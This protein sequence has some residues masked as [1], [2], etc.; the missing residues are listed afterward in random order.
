VTSNLEKNIM[1]VVWSLV[2]AAILSLAGWAY[3]MGLRVAVVETR[4]DGIKDALTA[5]RE[6]TKETRAMLR[7]AL[8]K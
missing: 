4:I 7:E 5:V 1:K 3:S 2:T 8:G 6:D